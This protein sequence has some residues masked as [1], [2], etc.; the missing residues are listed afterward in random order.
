MQV[1]R[2]CGGRDI[3][4][5]LCRGGRRQPVPGGD[6]VLHRSPF[7]GA[8]SAHE[9]LSN[10]NSSGIN[11]RWRRVDAV[12]G[13]PL[14]QV[15][16]A[17]RHHALLRAPAGPGHAGARAREQPLPGLADGRHIPGVQLRLR[18]PVRAP[19]GDQPRDRLLLHQH[20]G[21]ADGPLRRGLLFVHRP[22]GPGDGGRVHGAGQCADLPQPLHDGLVGVGGVRQRPA[23]HDP[24]RDFLLRL[25]SHH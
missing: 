12:W 14:V 4:D 18:L 9:R 6:P 5:L 15:L 17:A 25:S 16:R 20:V 3:H 2:L 13:G 11:G 8:Q 1:W 10:R 21:R 24:A 23:L 7:S 22:P 19:V